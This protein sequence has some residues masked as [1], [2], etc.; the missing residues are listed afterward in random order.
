MGQFPFGGAEP[1]ER[2]G[3]YGVRAALAQAHHPD[4]GERGVFPAA[5]AAELGLV[6]GRVRHFQHEP[7]DRHQPPPG[8]PGS[9]CPRPR[10]RHRDPLEQQPQRLSAQ[11]LPRLADRPRGRHRPLGAPRVHELQPAN[12]AAHHLLIPLT[13]EKAQRQHVINHNPGRQQPP[14]LFPAA[15]LSN[16]LID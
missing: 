9:W 5:R 8:H 12:Q 13:K 1:G 6:G 3:D 7:A 10:H 11:P 15:R 14:A 2:R 16:H 4:L